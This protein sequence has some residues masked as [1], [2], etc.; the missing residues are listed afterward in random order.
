ME[1]EL[2]L[3]GHLRWGDEMRHSRGG[4]CN[5]CGLEKGTN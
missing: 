1:K 3:V 2:S 5:V 4:Q